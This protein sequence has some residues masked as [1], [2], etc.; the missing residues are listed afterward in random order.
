M[1]FKPGKAISL[2]DFRRCLKLD[3]LL[4]I[5]HSN[6]RVVDTPAGAGFETILRVKHQDGPK[7]TPIFGPDNLLMSGV[8]YTDTVFRKKL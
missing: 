7:K 2:P 1:A 3:G 5:R 4:V 8:D 6:F